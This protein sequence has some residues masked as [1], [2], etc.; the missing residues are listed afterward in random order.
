M[1]ARTQ[2]VPDAPVGEEKKPAQDQRPDVTS[3][4]TSGPLDTQQ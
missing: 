4:G 2:V 3:T 1:L